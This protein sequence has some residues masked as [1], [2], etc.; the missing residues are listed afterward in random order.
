MEQEQTGSLFLREL[1]REAIAN[2]KRWCYLNK[3]TMTEAV[4]VFITE[5]GRE[6]SS[7]G[8]CTMPALVNRHK[9]VS[10]P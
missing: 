3:T 2:F 8:E 5:V 4:E 10:Q 1:P 7:L 6:G 9:K